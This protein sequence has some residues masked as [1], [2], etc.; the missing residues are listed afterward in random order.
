MDLFPSHSTVTWS[1]VPGLHPMTKPEPPISP[2]VQI[3]LSERPDPLARKSDPTLGRLEPVLAFDFGAVPVSV[4]QHNRLI[5]QV[6]DEQYSGVSRI[7]A[8]VA[9]HDSVGQLG[10]HGKERTDCP[11]RAPVRRLPAEA[12]DAGIGDLGGRPPAMS[13][14]R[15]TTRRKAGGISQ[16]H[17]ADARRQIKTRP[18]R[19]PPSAMSGGNLRSRPWSGVEPLPERWMHWPGPQARRELSMISQKATPGAGGKTRRPGTL[20]GDIRLQRTQAGWITGRKPGASSH[21]RFVLYP[22]HRVLG[23]SY[24]AGSPQPAGDAGSLTPPTRSHSQLTLT[25]STD[26]RTGGPLS[27]ASGGWILGA[28]LNRDEEGHSWR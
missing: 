4:H 27:N 7:P 1:F 18:S 2:Q 14:G 22:G 23:A 17:P 10:T 6:L 11:S 20:R 3:G 8:P 9:N 16:S 13:F 24:P 26:A 21:Y 15:R 5:T 25:A 19:G 28:H 12:H